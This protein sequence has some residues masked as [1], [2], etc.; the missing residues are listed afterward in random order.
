[1][2]EIPW[3]STE[4]TMVFDDEVDLRKAAMHLLVCHNHH[5]A[6]LADRAQIIGSS[7]AYDCLEET[8][9]RFYEVG[10]GE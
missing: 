9:L 3:I 7:S 8:G 2:P 10:E 4:K 6:V 5:F 1:M